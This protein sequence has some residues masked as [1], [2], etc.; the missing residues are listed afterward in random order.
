MLRDLP[1]VD[2]V[3][4][5]EVLDRVAHDKLG[6]AGLN[7]IDAHLLAAPRSIRSAVLL[8]RDKRRHTV[9]HRLNI[10]IDIES[11]LQ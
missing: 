3:A 4:D 2:T 5:E 10:A 11:R 6:G 8:T 1:T 9:A 7:Y